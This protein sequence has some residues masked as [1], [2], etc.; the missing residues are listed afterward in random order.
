MLFEDLPAI[1]RRHLD[2]YR[3][4]R[5]KSQSALYGRGLDMEALF[6]LHQ[7]SNAALDYQAQRHFL[8]SNLDRIL[9]S[10]LALDHNG[11][12]GETRESQVVQSLLSDMLLSLLLTQLPRLTEPDFIYDIV[13][14]LL[15]LD[16]P[17]MRIPRNKGMH[18][19]PTQKEH[20]DLDILRGRQHIR[21]IKRS[22]VSPPSSPL[23]E[24]NTKP[25]DVAMG[26]GMRNRAHARSSSAQILTQTQPVSTD[27]SSKKRVSRLNSH[28]SMGNITKQEIV[29]AITRL[30]PVGRERSNATLITKASATAEKNS[31]T[32]D[33]PSTT[34][35][36]PPGD[37]NSEHDAPT[38]ERSM[39][40]KIISALK[41]LVQ[42]LLLK[43][44]DPIAYDYNG[45]MLDEI[46]LVFIADLFQLDVFHTYLWGF[47]WLILRP[48]AFWFYRP[49]VNEVLITTAR[50]I[51]TE[52]RVAEWVSDIQELLWPGGQW[53]A[54]PIPKTAKQKELTRDAVRVVLID[55]LRELDVLDDEC[56]KQTVDTLMDMTSYE[57]LNQHLLYILI[58]VA[59][60]RLFPEWETPSFDQL[61]DSESNKLET[62]VS[63]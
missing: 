19:T 7:P 51:L 16:R 2:D 9:S 29:E 15:T 30:Q 61:L 27:P 43:S 60:T 56:I 4:C 6:R 45:A 1:L 22:A 54:P 35:A 36:T 5:E 53:S 52:E 3:L 50:S 25:V 17:E 48:T 23:P 20:R 49:A 59:L 14:Q 37:S 41:T 24:L 57:T 62:S 11:I 38:T 40:S 26:S 34:A 55:R 63:R 10:V 31:V 58:E 44:S 18:R 39:L 33:V 12:G 13:L 28:K 8:G 32:S 21:T 47:I 42:V 46:W